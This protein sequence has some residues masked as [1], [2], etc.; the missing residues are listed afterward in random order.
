MH[1][2]VVQVN[3]LDAFGGDFDVSLV[4]SL[5]FRLSLSSTLSPVTFD[6]SQVANGSDTW[7]AFELVCAASC[8]SW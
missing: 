4:S 2:S 3:K 7:R 5:F 1:S 8:V 6:Y